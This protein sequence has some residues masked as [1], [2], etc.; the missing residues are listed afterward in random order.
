[1]SPILFSFLLLAA[2]TGGI[3]ATP[4]FALQSYHAPAPPERDAWFGD[5]KLKHFAMSYVITAGSFSAARL[6]ADR[7][8]S[9]TTGIALGV[10]AGILKEVYDKRDRRRIS[11]KDLF[12]DALGITAGAVIAKQ[13]R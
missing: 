1:M 4:R 7:D 13:T 3:G 11:V 5:D 2:D 8:A 6:V 12:W 9:V 10:A